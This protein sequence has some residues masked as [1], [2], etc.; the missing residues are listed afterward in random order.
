MARTIKTGLILTGDATGAVKAVELT[1]NQ[2]QKLNTTGRRTQQQNKRQGES[3]SDVAKKA[4]A[5]AA[6]IGGAAIAAASALVKRQL[7]VIDSTAKVSDKLGIATESLTA[8]RIQA[9]LSGVAA[10]TLDMGLQRMVRR[11]AEAAAGTGEAKNALAELNLN[12]AALARL[13]PDKQFAAI[14]DAM[15]D[16]ESQSDRVRLAFKLFDSEGVAL[17]NT[18][19]GGSAA[20]AEAAEFTEQWG[21]AINRVDSAKIEQANDS[22]TRLSAASEGFWKQLT[23]RVAPAITGVASELL[24]FSSG[25]GTAQEQADSAFN[26]IARGAGV[27]ADIG[28]GLQVVWKGVTVIVAEWWA[29]VAQALAS[30]D[31]W[32]T[33]LL[34]KLPGWAG[35]GTFSESDLL[36]GVTAALRNTSDDLSSELDDLINKAMPSELL[37]QKIEEW[38]REATEAAKKVAEESNVAAGLITEDLS[39]VSQAVE[40]TTTKSVDKVKKD[41]PAAANDFAK[42]WEEATKRIDSAFADVWRGTFDSFSSFSDRLKDGFQQLLGEL[43]HRATTQPILISLGLG[44]SGSAFAGTGGGNLLAG[45]GGGGLGVSNISNLF[46]LRNLLSGPN[47]G[48]TGLTDAAINTLFNLGFQDSAVFLGNSLQS[49]S[50]LPGGLVGGGLITGGAGFAGGAL[51][52]RL[53]TGLFGKTPNSAI[54]S[55]VGGVGGALA[56]SSLAALGSFGGPIGAFV[57]AAIGGILDAAF[58]GDGKKR[59]ALG[60][61]AGADV[62]GAVTAASGLQLSTYTKRVGQEGVDAANNLLQAFLAIDQTLTGALA[63][64]GVG[65]NLAGASLVGKSAAFGSVPGGDFFGSATYN[66]VSPEQLEQA[67]DNFTKAWIQAVTQQIPYSLSSVL[68]VVEQD[69]DTLTGTLL[70]LVNIFNRMETSGTDILETARE[71]AEVANRSLFESYT[72]QTEAAIRL[73]G[74]YDGSVESLQAF[75]AA[76]IAQRDTAFLVAQQIQQAQASVASTFGGARDRIFESLLSEEELYT[77]R[78]SQIADL[79]QEL[80]NSLDPG[81]IDE[82]SRQIASLSQSAFGVL[83]QGQ[84]EAVGVELLAFL[85]QTERLAATRLNLAGEGVTTGVRQVD[86]AFDDSVE[87]L[88]DASRMQQNA[89]QTF[90]DA[91]QAWLAWLQQNTGFVPAQTPAEVNA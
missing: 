39:A 36:Q 28:R 62:P 91:M 83:D 69:A 2:L 60:V 67:A 87:R 74:A 80:A 89:A 49:I 37:A 3:F 34:N 54:G 16:V 38:E 72:E 70:G 59:V 11:V 27:V 47:A 46:S 13:S 4:S 56:G 18:L 14:A 85:S 75:E 78:R 21:L 25:F 61:R 31:S 73:A 29:T 24:E 64:R 55:T 22:M 1:D 17:V 88:L 90:S 58:G 81:R 5:Y 30:V 15:S 35:G 20:A 26:A 79:S 23:V 32:I 41:A 45:G 57:G 76:M 42:A 77:L 52:S 53:G 65:V 12:A 8:M 66:R 7:E 51:G 40:K 44:A 50:G 82:I 19:K 68:N 9:E 6:V 48:L 71:L 43:A 10:N 63:Q 33:A 84:R 86:A